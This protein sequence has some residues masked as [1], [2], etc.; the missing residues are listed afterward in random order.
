[1]YNVFKRM[2]IWSTMEMHKMD[3]NYAAWSL[4]NAVEFYKHHRNTVDQLYESEKAFLPDVIKKVRSVLDVGCGAGGFS[5]IMKTLQPNVYYVGID[6]APKMIDA[7]RILYPGTKFEV[8]D[9]NKINYP[10]NSFDLVF[11]TGVIHHNPNYKEMID[12]MYRVSRKYCIFDLPRLVPVDY[13]FDATESYMTLKE[14]F[15]GE[16]GDVSKEATRVPYFIINAKTI[17]DYLLNELVPKPKKLF[18]VGYY[19][20]TNP[21]VTMPFE[22]ICFCVVFIE[23]GSDGSKTRF[24]VD[25]PED[26]TNLLQ[27]DNVE[28]VPDFRTRFNQLL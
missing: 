11:C 22:E 12:E 16:L 27:Y 21:S 15:E 6:V 23:K 17:F 8:A 26:I 19:G 2:E 24:G 25:L 4:K 28:L 5:K 18:A 9:G 3:K 7:A 20:R 1:M 10:D 13:K 14:R